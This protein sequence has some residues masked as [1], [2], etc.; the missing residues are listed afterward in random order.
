MPPDQLKILPIEGKQISPKS[1]SVEGQEDVIEH[2]L[3]LC[4]PRRLLPGDASDERSRVLPVLEGRCGDPTHA[5]ERSNVS[6]DQT[7]AGGVEGTCVELFGYDAR[8]VRPKDQGSKLLLKEG[9][10]G[11]R[12][13]SEKIDV[14]VEEDGQRELSVDVHETPAPFAKQSA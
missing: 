7:D 14:R 8:Q 5:L 9:R 2:L 12:F 1:P 6:L 11:G 4:L 10:A 3:N 13:Q